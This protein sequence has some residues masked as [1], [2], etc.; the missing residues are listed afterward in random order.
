MKNIQ[1]TLIILLTSFSFSICGQNFKGTVNGILIVKNS[2][3]KKLLFDF[4]ASYCN[5]ENEAYDDYDSPNEPDETYTGKTTSGKTNI[6]YR[7]RNEGSSL[8]IE[9]NGEWFELSN[10]DG[11]SDVPLEGIDYSF[12]YEKKAKYLIL[13]ITKELELKNNY[14]NEVR[15]T[16]KV[17]PNSTL[18][19][20]INLTK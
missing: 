14:K 19:F 17:L 5:M 13:R 8:G 7:L 1:I 20:A 9:L 6:K 10:I 4:Q 3:N 18:V 12:E 16:I 15:K 2:E 11:A